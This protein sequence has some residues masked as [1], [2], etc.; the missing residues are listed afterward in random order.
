MST[1]TCFY[2]KPHRK[3]KFPS[4][5][6]FFPKNFQPKKMTRIDW[7]QNP[8]V[9]HL[10]LRDR[11]AFSFVSHFYGVLYSP[12]AAPTYDIC[13]DLLFETYR[14]YFGDVDE[15]DDEFHEAAISF[16]VKSSSTFGIYRLK[17]A[18]MKKLFELHYRTFQAEATKTIFQPESVIIIEALFFTTRE[19]FEKVLRSGLIDLEHLAYHFNVSAYFLEL[20]LKSHGLC[21]VTTQFPL[22]STHRYIPVDNHFNVSGFFMYLRYHLNSFREQLEKQ[23]GLQV[24]AVVSFMM[25]RAQVA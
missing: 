18:T 13:K 4:D 11:L 12:S 14:Y 8:S 7:R 21:V 6:R 2:S 9:S 3:K 15:Y 20:F 16:S 22:F 24:L 23:G 17:V 5:H 25:D 1:S 19:K 10:S